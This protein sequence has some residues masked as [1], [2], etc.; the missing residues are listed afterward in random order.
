M[1]YKLVIFDMD[2]TLVDTSKGI[3]NSHRY[4][5]KMMGLSEPSDA[6]L[7]GVIGGPLL[8]TYQMRFG[9]SAAD[10]KKTVKIYRQYYAEYGIYESKLYD[11]MEELLIS[12]REHEIKLGVATLKAERFAKIMLENMGIANLFDVIYGVDEN[13]K[14]TTADLIQLCM[15]TLGMLK[16]ETVMIGDSIHD[17]NGARE[18]GIDFIGVTYGFG[19]SDEKKEQKWLMCSSIDELLDGILNKE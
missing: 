5:H 6:E 19:F 18:C 2:G 1:R 7:E 11:G 3:L 12:L 8:Q 16:Q 4:A 9:F 10:A 13:D 15:T 14:Q 17:L